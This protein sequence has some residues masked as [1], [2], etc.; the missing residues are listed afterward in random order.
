MGGRTKPRLAMEHIHRGKC[1]GRC[2]LLSTHSCI[3]LCIL[4]CALLRILLY[5]LLCVHYICILIC[6]LLSTHACILICI[7]LLLYTTLYITLCTTPY[8]TL[9]TTL[10]TTL[11]TTLTIH[12]SVYYSV[13]Y[14]VYYSV[15]CVGESVTG[16]HTVYVGLDMESGDLLAIYEWVL[17]CR[18]DKRGD[19]RRQKQVTADLMDSSIHN[20]TASL[21]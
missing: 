16:G 17:Q 13:H 4:L 7:L 19:T 1:L 12:Y 21:Q 20:N 9:Y 8:T 11:Y 6:I 14:S 10:C 15:Y 5:I 18:T 2:I 3:L